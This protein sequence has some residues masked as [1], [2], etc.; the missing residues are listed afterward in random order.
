M[1][2]AE[3]RKRAARF[4]GLT[5]VQSSPSATT[6]GRDSE[7]DRRP[8]PNGADETGK[9]TRV[10]PDVVHGET[11]AR[12]AS[13]PKSLVV[14]T[15]ASRDGV[16]TALRA[17]SVHNPRTGHS[18]EGPESSSSDPRGTSNSTGK[19]RDERTGHLGEGSASASSG[20]PTASNTSGSKTQGEHTG[21]AREGLASSSSD[22]R[23]SSNSSGRKSHRAGHSEEGLASS[24]SNAR[25]SSNTSDSKARGDHTGRFGKGSASNLSDARTPSHSTGS[26]PQ[27]DRT[28]CS[29]GESASAP[30]DAGTASNNN[31]KLRDGGSKHSR[32]ASTSIS[33]DARDASNVSGESRG[34][35]DIS[36][37]K[38]SRAI[39][40]PPDST[41]RN[42]PPN[43]S[44]GGRAAHSGQSAGSPTGQT[45]GAASC[46]AMETVSA[47]PIM[48]MLIRFRFRFRV[49]GTFRLSRPI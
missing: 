1:R 40:P 37:E 32:R 35:H 46:G 2:Y 45:R 42:D 15:V 26:K 21:H 16:S 41:S 5:G 11:G 38:S 7:G 12:L 34:D 29:R 48:D 13:P 22:T 24:S 14:I 19:S 20:V 39:V 43:A 27:D 10:P 25:T 47:R 4:S 33:A 31:R 3:V 9:H 18:P 28:G 17:R 49:A 6:S 44:R 36:V 23:A 8:P 30:P